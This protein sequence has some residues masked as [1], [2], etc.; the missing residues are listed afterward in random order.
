MSRPRPTTP[1]RQPST[2]ATMRPALMT[3]TASPPPGHDGPF[4]PRT[5][6]WP[7]QPPLGTPCRHAGE[8][9]RSPPQCGRR[10][11]RTRGPVTDVAAD[12]VEAVDPGRPTPGGVRLR[13]LVDR[14]SGR[15]HVDESR[16][17]RSGHATGR[18]CG[19]TRYCSGP[20]RRPR[21]RPQPRRCRPR[22]GDRA[23]TRGTRSRPRHRTDARPSPGHSSQAS[24]TR[25]PHP[26]RHL[27][28]HRSKLAAATSRSCGVPSESSGRPMGP[29]IRV[30]SLAWCPRVALRCPRSAANT[31]AVHGVRTTP[32]MSIGERWRGN[33]PSPVTGRK[34]GSGDRYDSMLPQ[35][36][37]T[38][39]GGS[40]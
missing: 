10:R 31:A 16:P 35:T 28:G 40:R 24:S 21:P 33:D 27:P 36:M 20:A 30:A 25:S 34:S 39:G 14:H 18:M 2:R 7:S 22:P 3:P 15:S 8:S 19:M 32:R 29:P 23:P 37:G 5:A 4:D 12:V 26:G 6:V 9:T 13:R 17:R 38:S 11:S 1:T